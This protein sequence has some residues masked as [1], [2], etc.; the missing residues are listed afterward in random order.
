MDGAKTGFARRLR[1]LR[2]LSDDEL[3][4]LA[5][6]GDQHAFGVIFE[7]YHEPLYRYSAALLRNPEL[8]AD[9]LQTTAL[10]AMQGLKEGERTIPLRPWLHRIVH[11]QSLALL[12]V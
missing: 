7:R 8:A 10:A 6:G 1:P 2:R 5:A 12:D 4:A 11:D 3:A 9:V